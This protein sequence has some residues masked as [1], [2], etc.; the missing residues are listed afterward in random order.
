VMD[1]GRPQRRGPSRTGLGPSLCAY[2]SREPATVYSAPDVRSRRV[3]SKYKPTRD[4]PGRI[5]VLNRR[6][7][8]GWL[9]VK[10]PYG[11]PGANW[12]RAGDLTTPAR[13]S[14]PS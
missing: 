3:K 6:H 4:E 13:C 1:H 11:P 2:V 12:M 10:T 5:A 9:L 7:P 8:P 14:A